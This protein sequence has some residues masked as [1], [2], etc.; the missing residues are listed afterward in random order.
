MWGEGDGGERWV[1]VAHALLVITIIIIIIGV[2][3]TKKHGS[4]KAEELSFYIVIGLL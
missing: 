2:Y 4:Q 1:V 3:S